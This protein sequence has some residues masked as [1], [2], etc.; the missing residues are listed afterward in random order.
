[1]SASEYLIGVNDEHGL[2]PPTNGKRTPIM[3]YLD[4]SIY[5]NEF[6]RP[7][8][9]YCAIALL[10]SGFRTFDLHPEIQDTSV[11]VRVNRANFARCDLLVTFAYN[12]F[13]SGHSFNSVSG[14]LTYFSDK[15][16]FA[17]NSQTLSEDVYS[18]I[19]EKSL[20]TNGRGV[21][22]LSD[23][24][25]LRSVRCPSTLIE[26]GF[27]TN[28]REARLMLDPD[29]QKSIAYAAAA[30]ICDYTDKA[31]TGEGNPADYPAIM[32]GSENSYVKIAQYL[33][34]LRGYPLDT[35]G[36]FG[37]NTQAATIEFQK[38]NGLTADGIIGKQSWSKLVLQSPSIYILKKGSTGSAVQYLQYKLLSKLYPLDADGIFGSE[39]ENAVKLFQ[40]ESG[41]VPD[42]IVGP[43]TF[44]A[45][46]PLSSPRDPEQ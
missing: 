46:L 34:N 14:V 43:I 26:A 27:M 9:I 5:E 17:E 37:N 11:S 15:S 42:G 10:R 44:S 30:G 40:T 13:G 21:G 45:L 19:I 39:T 41:L 38:F 31:Y 33:L 36:V 29:W 8:K 18:A 16:Y 4:R 6:N 25:V 28:L 12:A 24:G 35:D 20:Q 3:P 1:M 32:R 7:A 22:V 23:V 2:D